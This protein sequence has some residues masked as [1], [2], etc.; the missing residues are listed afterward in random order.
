ME[1]LRH[2]AL[3]ELGVFYFFL[4]RLER[5]LGTLYPMRTSLKPRYWRGLRSTVDAQ[6][7]AFRLWSAIPTNPAPMP[8][9]TQ[10]LYA[11]WDRFSQRRNESHDRQM[12]RN[13]V[14]HIRLRAIVR[15]ADSIFSLN[16]DIV[17]NNKPSLDSY[18]KTTYD[19]CVCR[20]FPA[21]AIASCVF[22]IAPK[23]SPLKGIEFLFTLRFRLKWFQT[24]FHFL[25][26][27]HLDQRNGQQWETREFEESWCMAKLT[28]LTTPCLS[29][30]FLMHIDP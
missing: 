29:P 17:E 30:S 15:L 3:P 1:M 18:P 7:C 14:P 25:Q 12:V 9:Q 22:P 24:Y 4:H 5:I 10:V 16:I 23:R 6:H 2:S 13:D 28:Q 21:Y 8:G 26:F 11:I 20:C 19:T 27:R